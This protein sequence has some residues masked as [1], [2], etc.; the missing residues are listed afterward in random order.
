MQNILLLEPNYKNKYPPIGLMKIATF[1]KSILHD[2]VRFA[3]GSLPI[4]LSNT[5][6]DRV[7]VTTLFTFEWIETIKA[8]RYAKNIV[9]S[10]EN[11]FVGGIAATLM[12]DQI[13]QETGIHPTRGSLNASNKINLPGEECIDDI[14]PDYA[15]LDDISNQ[16]K[17]PFFDAYFL[18][19]TKGC[20]MHCGFCAVQTLEPNYIPYMNIKSK[21]LSIDALYGPKKDLLLMDNNVLRSSQFNKIIDDILEAGFEKG[22][23]YISP[24]T[25][26]RI[27]RYVDFNQGLDAN[28]LTDKKAQRLGE[29]A[30]RPARIA[31]DHLED[32]ANYESAIRLCAN[33]GTTELSNYVLYN[34]ED[35][36]AKGHQYLADMP[37]DL[38][39]RMKITLELKEDINQTLPED[40]KISIFSFPMRYIPLSARE[41]GYVGS[42]WN[43]KFLRSFQCML[44]PTQGKGVGNRSFFEA[45]FGKNSDEFIRFL[46]MPESLLSARGHF[47][48]GGRGRVGET[49]NHISERRKTWDENQL[50][51]SEWNRLFDR[52]S[53]ET[54]EFIEIIKDNEYLPEKFFD[55]RSENQKK[56]YLHYLTKPRLISLLGLIKPKSPTRDMVF[57]YLTTEFPLFLNRIVNYLVSKKTQQ[58]YMFKNFVDFFRDVG[59]HKIIDRLESRD[60]DEDNQLIFWSR[61]CRNSTYSFI[62]FE[63]I[64]IYRR[65]V[66]LGVLPEKDHIAAR[67]SIR[68][69]ENENLSSILLNHLESFR[70]KCNELIEVELGKQSLFRSS[71]I[72]CSEISYKLNQTGKKSEWA[73]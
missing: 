51:I 47:A 17:Y 13:F 67:I 69:L 56:L 39:N 73:K 5:K 28:F 10:T 42:K 12:P 27:Q 23:N 48:V 2:Y 29:I 60:Y 43:P 9:N 18:S 19:A 34:S 65:F 58:S 37:E 20:G 54:N 7:Y 30:L 1:H 32:R 33:Y 26:K 21:I 64:R 50:Q 59:L 4:E 14:I 61:V 25:G 68:Q 3:K 36:G 38:Y 62:D 41:R 8:I 15:M 16:Y 71:E 53:S 63:L 49:S 22:A 11:I 44:I 46:Y 40:K 24:R 35:F 66:E 55:C 52:L 70:K 31:F 57:N 72:I 45:D 6:W